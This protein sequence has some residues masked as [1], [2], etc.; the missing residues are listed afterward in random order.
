MNELFSANCN[1]RKMRKM[2][3]LCVRECCKM[4]FVYKSKAMHK[5]CVSYA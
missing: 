4:V 3:K 5:G 2:C 1:L